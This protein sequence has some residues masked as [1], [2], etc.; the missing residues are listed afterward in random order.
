MFNLLPTLFPGMA[1]YQ[2]HYD[3]HRPGQKYRELH[4]A[5]R[6]LSDSYHGTGSTFFVKTDLEATEIRDELKQVVD[7][8]D[9]I[10]VTVI[11][12]RTP[13]QWA[14]NNS[15]GVAEWLKENM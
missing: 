12:K 5:I 7:S 6:D 13:V 1:V 15:S 3:L 10:I 11:G 2:I 9:T 14:T 4:D 8:S